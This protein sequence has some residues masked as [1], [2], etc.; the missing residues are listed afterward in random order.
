MLE[1]PENYILFL[2]SEYKKVKTINNTLTNYIFVNEKLSV[3]KFKSFSKRIFLE[4]R[5]KK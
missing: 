4:Q 2:S 1:F 3:I 5:K